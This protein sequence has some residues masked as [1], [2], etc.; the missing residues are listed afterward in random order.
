M[1]LNTENLLGSNVVQGTTSS[2]LSEKFEAIFP[3]WPT[4]LAT[5]IS[6]LVLMIVLTKFLYKPVKGMHDNR[7]KYIQDNID[8]SE[9]QNK[10]AAL[11]REKAND[12]L[13]KA[14]LV[15]AELMK[16]AKL[17]A[18][19][20]REIEIAKAHEAA[21]KVIADAKLNMEAQQRKFEE[22]SKE[23]I[24]DVALQAASK[25]IEKE[26]D[27]KTN[28]KIVSDYIKAKK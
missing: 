7:K 15:A 13:I 8:S 2:E 16:N 4:V 26:V 10:N 18:S 22:E 23:A 24:I 19:E 5:I 6:F 27:S 9:V 11:D 17:Q 21:A 3:A 14:R 20:A 25:I 28:R 12:E 1:L